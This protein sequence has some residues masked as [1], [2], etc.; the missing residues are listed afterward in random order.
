MMILYQTIKKAPSIYM[1]SAWREKEEAPSGSNVSVGKVAC[2]MT[3]N[4]SLK[5]EI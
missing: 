3:Q 4:D 5:N 2:V 1:S